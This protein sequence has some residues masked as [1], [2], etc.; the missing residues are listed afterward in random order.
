MVGFGK[1]DERGAKVLGFVS[2]VQ[3]GFLF[4]RG[5]GLGGRNERTRNL[6]FVNHHVLQFFYVISLS[7]QFLPTLLALQE[8]G[9]NR[10]FKWHKKL[11]PAIWLEKLEKEATCATCWP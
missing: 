11:A 9:H 1:S 3:R 5:L 7:R 4:L 10:D 2:V 8:S 6:L